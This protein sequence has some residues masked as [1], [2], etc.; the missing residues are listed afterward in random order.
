MCS[1]SRLVARTVR[2]GHAASSRA[3]TPAAS[4]T[5]SKLS[6][7]RSIRRS[8][9][10][11]TSSSSSGRSMTSPRPTARATATSRALASRAPDR[12]TKATPSANP[13]ARS[14]AALIASVVLPVPPGPVN[15]SRRTEPSARRPRIWA[16]SSPRPISPAALAGRS[17]PTARTVTSGGN[18]EGR[19]GWTSWNRCSGRPRS[20]RRCSPRSTRSA[21]AGS[22]SRASAA[23]ASDS[24]TWPPWPAAMIRAVR[25]SVG[26]KKSPPR[27]SA[28]PQCTPIRT[29][30]GP[31]SRPGLGGEAELRRQA[32]GRRADRAAE[33]RHHPVAGGLDHLAGRRL[34][35]PA[36][37]RVVPAAGR[38]SSHRGSAPRAACCPPRP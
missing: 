26:P 35:R 18:V 13:G 20:L 7:T 5:C 15:V 23:A 27:S 22:D 16:S 3:T 32:G 11:S 21:P 1:A 12:S 36:K 25:F 37:D 31:V 28:C 14:S 24:R 8:R 4:V 19:A 34:D 33:H 6:R 9:R 17:A 10:R 30:S 29:R 2:R 38:P